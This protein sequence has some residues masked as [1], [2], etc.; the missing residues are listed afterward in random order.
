MQLSAQ[1]YI[2]TKSGKLLEVKVVKDEPTSLV[3]SV[4]PSTLTKR[5]SKD[6]IQNYALK[7][8]PKKRSSKLE[9]IDTLGNRKCGYLL[10]ADKDSLYFWNENTPYHPT[11][12]AYF[13]QP[14]NDVQR[15]AIHRK[16]NFGKGFTVGFAFGGVFGVT[17]AGSSSGGSSDSYLGEFYVT[18]SYGGDLLLAGA[19]FGSLGGLAGGLVGMASDKHI[20][21]D[22]LSAL[23]FETLLP[24]IQKQ[25]M[26]SN[27][28]IFEL[29]K[30]HTD[31][32]CQSTL[33]EKPKKRLPSRQ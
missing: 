22:T 28:P 29:N 8:R 31:C 14:V 2:L 13:A 1:D 6:T 7:N 4:L 25:T 20:Q 12:G 9:I 16:G 17:A 26:L 5:I 27:R 23:N 10:Y 19:L 32:K 11:K 33:F 3:Y 21:Y 30:I 24:G 15:F 18:G